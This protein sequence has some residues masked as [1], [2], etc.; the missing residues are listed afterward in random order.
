MLAKISCVT[1]GPRIQYTAVQSV[2][3]ADYAKTDFAK[4]VDPK[5]TATYT[6]IDTL[7]IVHC[8]KLQR[9]QESPTEVIVA[10]VL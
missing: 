9:S 5:E 3:D 4:H 6:V 10:D 7:P 1:T 8:N 2:C